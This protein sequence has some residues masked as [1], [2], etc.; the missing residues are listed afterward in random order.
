MSTPLH[1]DTQASSATLRRAGL[2][3]SLGLVGGAVFAALGVPLAWLM[4]ALVV[5]IVGIFAGL[6]LAVPNSLRMAMASVLGVMIGSTFTP[7]ILAGLA[8]W[9]PSV[10][11][12]LVV[13]AI[14]SAT[15]T[16]YFRLIGGFDQP[17]AY[18]SSAPG[19]LSEMALVGDSFG[20]DIR[21]ITLVHATRVAVVVT[22][23]P[24]FFRIFYGL[25]APPLPAD[26]SGLFA[27]PLNESLV[28]I[29]CA[30]IGIPVAKMLRF[31]APAFI[32]PLILSIIVHMSELSRATPPFALIAVA[33]VVLGASVGC[34]FSGLQFRHIWRTL[35]VAV[36]AALL[37][38]AIAIVAASFAAPFLG[39]DIASLVLALTPGG[40]VEMGLVALSMGVS[41]AYVSTIHIIRITILVAAMPIV[42]RLTKNKLR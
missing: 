6:K 16:A 40:V 37:F 24:F 29:L 39:L 3:L 13:I 36:G 30:V 31:P 12:L 1:T 15:G 26:G 33:Q 32:G 17:T 20:G 18:F 10:I 2:T 34:R 22:V 42:Y 8:L 9:W 38:I 19:G 4:G 21:L 28:L 25:D 27:I 7:D 5:T 11:L 23:V 41:T 35:L 14:M